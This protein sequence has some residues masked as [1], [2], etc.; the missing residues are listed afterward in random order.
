MD[1]Q[2]I[3]AMALVAGAGAYLIYRSISVWTRSRS[4]CG[5]SCGC[6]PAANEAQSLIPVESLRT[7]RKDQITSSTEQGHA[8]S[9]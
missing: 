2:L 3:I 1:Y 4:G 7:L 6:K 8:R 9:L 5:G